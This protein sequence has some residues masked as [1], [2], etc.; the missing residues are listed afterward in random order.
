MALPHAGSGEVIAV[1]HGDDDLTQ[2]SALA[3]AK[4]D[5]MELIRL[6]LPK[7]KVMPE[8]HVPGEITLLCLR[9]D[10]SVD[11]HGR[12]QTLRS[13]QMLYLNGGQAHALRAEQD[14]LLLLTILLVKGF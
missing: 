10:V 7:G 2:F 11:A 14:S 9:G 8:H 1:Q 4:T 3:L 12:S 5:E 13:G 6:T